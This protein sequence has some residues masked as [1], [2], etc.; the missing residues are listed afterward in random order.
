MGHVGPGRP[1]ART[2]RVHI[3][4]SWRSAE[5][6]RSPKRSPGC[7]V[8]PGG[9]RGLARNPCKAA[10]ALQG[11]LARPR[12][13][14]RSPCKASGATWGHKA[15]RIL[16]RPRALQ[17]SPCKALGTLQGILARPPGPCKDPLQGPRGVLGGLAR[18]PCKASGALQGFLASRG[19]EVFPRE[20]FNLELPRIFLGAARIFT[21][22]AA[23]SD[24][25][26]P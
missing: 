25:S 9:P 8:A 16:A 15:T 2:G 7:L 14:A 21:D 5:L 10:G 23:A 18:N 17:G 22:S 12:G 26:I 24:R 4:G 1:A 3:Q 13:L 11:L 6:L 20:Y 19:I